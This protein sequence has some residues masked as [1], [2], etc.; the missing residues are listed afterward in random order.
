[1][2]IGIHTG[3][4]IAG[5]IGSTIVR[6]DIFGPDVLKANKIESNGIPGRIS[7]STDAKLML[8]ESISKE[9]LN[10]LNEV[11]I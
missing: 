9:E 5:I 8:K 4:I 2:R 10:S 7:V 3:T 1:M 11:K 6:Y